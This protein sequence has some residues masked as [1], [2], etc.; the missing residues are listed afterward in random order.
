M[1]RVFALVASLSAV[2]GCCHAAFGS[3]SD[4]DSLGGWK[5]LWGKKTGYFHTDIIRSRFW[6]V[7]PEG[8]AFL[9][10]GMEE[11]RG[12]EG[13]PTQPSAVAGGPNCVVRREGEAE[14]PCILR[15]GLSAQALSDAREAAPGFPDLFSPAFERAVDR[16]ARQDCAARRFDP[17]IVGY[18]LDDSVAWGGTSGSGCGLAMDFLK[19]SANDPGKSAIVEILRQRH[20]DDVRSVAAS[21]R[22][23]VSSWQELLEKTDWNFES[24]GDMPERAA[25]LAAI[26]RAVIARYADVCCNAVRRYDPNHLIFSP[27]FPGW[28]SREAISAIAD[29]VDAFCVQPHEAERLPVLPAQLYRDAGKPTLLLLAPAEWAKQLQQAAAFPFV[30]GCVLPGGKRAMDGEAESFYVAAARAKALVSFKQPIPRYEL[31]KRK[32]PIAIDARIE[33]WQGAVPIELETSPYSP[34]PSK[35]KATVWLMW[36]DNHIYMA[37]RIIDEERQGSTLTSFVGDDSIELV[38]GKARVL[39]GLRP[40]HHSVALRDK[41]TTRAAVVVRPVFAQA[42][43]RRIVGYTLEAAA[44]VPVIVP[45]GFIYRFALIFRSRGPAGPIELT[46]PATLA[47]DDPDTQAEFVLALPPK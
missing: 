26:S 14:F 17:F 39:I 45:P 35:V 37:G 44:E 43:E 22:L 25:D 31:R 8:N 6:L 7:D 15:L 41:E 9:V 21:W 13:A 47:L 23:T 3:P 40:G 30:I 28:V 12:A 1:R 27:P 24:G 38:A 11:N 29:A 34:A 20:A 42:G 36:D 5:R 4:F 18:I 19:L 33:D 16:A 2:L 46:H 10:L 32:M